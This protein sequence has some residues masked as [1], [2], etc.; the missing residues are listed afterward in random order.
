MKR[1]LNTSQLSKKTKL[2][3]FPLLQLLQVAP[4][5]WICEQADH[6][7]LYPLRSTC[8]DLRN[9]WDRLWQA[10]HSSWASHGIECLN[11]FPY[12]PQRYLG[13]KVTNVNRPMYCPVADW[14]GRVMKE[15]V[16]KFSKQ[17]E[18]VAILYL[19][20]KAFSKGN[21]QKAMVAGL[22]SHALLTD[23][24]LLFAI[25]LATCK[26]YDRCLIIPAEM[27]SMPV[28]C[29]EHTKRLEQAADDPELMRQ[30]EEGPGDR[31]KITINGIEQRYAVRNELFRL[32]RIRYD[33]DALL[34]WFVNYCP[35]AQ[36]LD[37]LE[38]LLGV[39]EDNH[40]IFA[41]R[42]IPDSKVK[43]LNS[44]EVPRQY[45]LESIGDHLC[46]ES[47]IANANHLAK[48][49]WVIGDRTSELAFSW[50]VM[51]IRT[52]SELNE[53]QVEQAL[54]TLL[55][56][57]HL[58]DDVPDSW[59]GHC[60]FIPLSILVKESS[61]CLPAHL[62]YSYPAS[63]QALERAATL[64]QEPETMKVTKDW[65]HHGCDSATKEI[66]ETTHIE[67]PHLATFLKNLLAK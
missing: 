4:F 36:Y 35:D 6:D 49:R 14:G 11:D 43:L 54:R 22:L 63:V 12:V 17:P 16:M 28:K 65:L 3:L 30:L 7:T 13:L 10:H 27:A 38:L 48:L 40:A 18:Y 53:Q 59:N 2:D 39:A 60:S 61:P 58:L 19:R 46:D 31:K 51:L 44:L 47:E 8:Q 37:M 29:I 45:D 24:V 9:E 25:V 41:L 5:D 15:R 32:T 67:E 34:Y 20:L 33:N 21:R 42:S 23:N 66:L 50:Q 52:N 62:L 56:S 1:T 26:P 57:S 55:E 64:C